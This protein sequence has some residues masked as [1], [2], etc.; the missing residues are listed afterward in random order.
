MP[1]TNHSGN[2]R[3]PGAEAMRLARIGARDVE[4]KRVH[5]L[6]AEHVIGVGERARHRQHDAALE[7]FGDA[8]RAFADQPLDGVRLPEVRGRRRRE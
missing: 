8:A 1:S 5:E 3:M 4:L 7:R 2:A 6:V